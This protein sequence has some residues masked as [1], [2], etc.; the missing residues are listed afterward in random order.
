M[1]REIDERIV[2]MRFDNKQFEENIQTSIGS[3][4]KLEKSL[5]LKDASKG[6]E[7][8]DSAAKK[9]NMSGISGA[10]E[11][12][13]AK[14]SALQIMGIAALTN[15][16]NSAI[17]AGKK[18]VSALTIDP[19]KTGFTEYETQI[20]AVQTILANTESKG[21]TLTDVNKALDE[22]N[23]YADKTIYNFT[24]MT[25]NIGTFTAAGTDLDTSVKAIKG[26]ANLAAVS[27][28]TSQQASTA[29]YQLSQAL[30]SG[31]VK[32]MD[33]N[34]VVNAGM[35]GQV[36]QDALKETA[37]VHGIE[38]DKM[39]EN[40]GS[41][42]ETL[43]DGW[44]SSEILTETLEKFTLATE[45]LT[46]A[47]IEKNREML[48]SK[49]YTE[50]QIDAIFKMGNTATN[51]ATK[52]KT[53]T[54][55]FDTLKEAAQSGWT[56]TWEII[57]GDFEEAKEL[58]TKVS[59]VIGAIIGKSAEARNEMLIGWKDLG[60]RTVLIEA[61]SN[62]FQGLMNI[63]EPISQ[64]FEEIFPPIT[65]KQLFKITEVLR[66][67]L[68]AFK[69][70][71][72]Y[73]NTFEIIKRTFKGIFALLD[74]GVQ[75]VKALAGGIGKVLGYMAPAGDGLLGLTAKLGDTIVKFRDFLKTGDV[76]DKVV[77][78]IATAIGKV[79]SGMKQFVKKISN[80]TKVFDNID[81]S[82]VD[83]FTERI[84]TR[85]E[86]LS[87]L[88]EG[89]EK[90]F[91]SMAN[92][93]KKVAPVVYTVVGKMGEFFGFLGEKIS[94]A[95]E[96][97][98]FDILYDIINVTISGGL[99][100]GIKKI[101]NA[102]EG[103]LKSGSGVF[104]N[105]GETFGS[106]KGT[107]GSLKGILDGVKD[108]FKAW[109]SE[110]KSKVLL[111]IAKAVGILAIALIAL[112]LV[113]SVKLSV[114][115]GAITVMFAELF[116]SMAL[117]SKLMGKNGTSKLTGI[118]TTLIGISSAVLILSIAMV[119]VASLDA[120]G[121][122]KGLIAITTLVASMVATSVILS[123][124]SGKMTKGMTSL[125]IMAVAIRSLA[126]AV[127][128]LG[129]L[130]IA[131]LSKGLLGVG[132]LMVELVGFMKLA[133]SNKMS[134]SSA[135]GLLILGAAINVLATAISK[136]AAMSV[137]S[138]LKGLGVM[139]IVLAELVIFTKLTQNTK[140]VMST[141]TG[142][143]ILGAAMLILAKAIGVMGDFSWEQI[144]KGLLTMAT[145]LGVVIAALHLLPK[146]VMSKG[147]GLVIIASALVILGSA[148][149]KMG[150][151]SW[152]EVAKALVTLA[153]SLTVI[154][155]AMHF[156]ASATPGALAMSALA[157][158]IG[159]LTAALMKLGSMSW[160][161][162]ARSLVML[163]GTFTILGLAGL[164]LTPIV[165]TLLGLGAAI[166]LLGV[167][168][169]AAGVGTLAFAAG[170]SVLSVAL[171]TSSVSL[172]AVVSS[173]LGLIPL[174]L[175]KVGEG[176]IA[177]CETIE[178]GSI[179]I[180]KAV[181]TV[182][183]AL[184]KVLTDCIPPLIN[185]LGVLLG[186]LLKFIVKYIPKIIDVGMKLIL[187]LLKGIADNIDKVVSTA[188]DIIVNFLGAI[189]QSIPKVIQAGVDLIL[190]FIYGIANAVR[191]NKQPLIDAVN[192]LMNAVFEAIGAWIGNMVDCGK[193]LILGLIEGIKGAASELW[194]AMV[195]VVEDAWNGVKDFFGIES[196][197]KE[198]IAVG[199]FVD[200]GIAIGFDKYGNIVSKSATG[201]GETALDSMK[202]ALSDVS[203]V[204]DA[205]MDMTP[206][207]RPVVDLTDVESGEK[208]LSSMLGGSRTI[209]VDS[210]NIKA[211]AIS[212][213]MNPG[214][215]NNIPSGASKQGTSISFTQNNY[216]PKA[217]SRVDIYRQTK[218]QFSAMERMVKA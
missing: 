123:K 119:A 73:E 4:D 148:L 90:M 186:E 98:D 22:L 131:S 169:V 205:D 59:D 145:A 178:E 74:I 172:V 115:L 181:T 200:Q 58:L 157:P 68:N 188:L 100:L 49:G 187:G 9:V 134:A 150:G 215:D 128:K 197:A 159:M 72:E 6:F 201:V 24:E 163:A 179:A 198:G 166:V 155:V 164:I 99:I 126:K 81:T 199:K 160:E 191:N 82:G 54:Q 117:F 14:F 138:L 71:T 91:Q 39:I 109:Q 140:H 190:S 70:W 16:T 56:Q 25:R 47:E 48:K 61:I 53:F 35:G 2:E 204:I 50:E 167:G 107:L 110:L 130:D 23:A 27:G 195:G 108:A 135:T 143:T 32:L 12:V 38:I 66:N 218:N 217:L 209:T 103:L 202:K 26:I 127:T 11:A 77:E 112:S 5:K 10:V 76:F 173:L 137:A 40:E 45:G 62:A 85:F 19:V 114:S 89:T 43:K 194:S 170:L 153:G 3:L 86:P 92:F 141:A 29:M 1:S 176:I 33:W 17:N 154:A 95:V 149:S 216:S 185:C 113:D 139:A 104:D 36:F 206:T 122:A 214:A 120:A 97:A 184:I 55:L 79:V 116:T 78:K 8:I 212:S 161:E 34:S 196:P 28:S 152:V 106:L 96:N 31:T 13:S 15:I 146:G 182:L 20:N 87:K 151:M 42:R 180:C 52:V 94:A 147:T 41:F 192:D 21:S 171:A 44:L 203:D 213:G 165:P 144:G 30:S 158:A 129:S 84:K 7:N 57:V 175:R 124:N 83:S 183:L 101:I 80:T 37:R 67:A 211:A 156:M 136:F 168:C 93:A 125:V 65:A 133:G 64:A 142:L 51:A 177:F 189:G 174:V 121:V 210:A 60:G 162:V 207:I 18:I 63:I 69:E 111:N 46:E 88:S 132:V 208:Q 102:F 118:T 75:I 105:L 193:D